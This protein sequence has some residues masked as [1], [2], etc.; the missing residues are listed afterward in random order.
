[1]VFSS[2]EL[3]M[4]VLQNGEDGIPADSKYIWV[5][6]SQNANGDPLTDDPTGAVYIGIAYNK[7]SIEESNNP[8]DYYWSKILGDKGEDAYTIILSN[9]NISFSVSYEDNLAIGDQSFTTDVRVFYGAT[10]RD[11]FVIGEIG[12]SNGIT[13]SKT[14]NSV[15]LSVTDSTK[16]TA[17]HGYF[18]IPISIDGLIFYKDMS[19]NTV[20]QGVPGS[21]GQSALNISLGNESQ[22]IPCNSE[23]VTLESFLIEIPFAAYEGFNKVACTA[24][25]GVLPSGITLGQNTGSTPD[26]DGLI[27]LNVARGSNLGGDEVLQGKVVI[28][29]IVGESEVIKNFTWTK[30][31]DGA[32]GE[33]GQFTLYSLESSAPVISKTFEDTFSPESITFSAYSMEG[34]S[35]DKTEYSGMFIIEE[36]TN[37]T[38]Y[39]TSYLSSADEQSVTF[40]PTSINVISIRCTLY[41]AGG[42]TSALDIYTVPVLTDVDNMRPIIDEITTS[43]S[44]V[45][46]KVDSVEKSIT[47]KVWQSDITTQINNYD[48]TTVKIIRDQVAETQTSLGEIRSTVSDVQTTLTNKADGSTVQTLSEKVSNIEQDANGFRQT[49]EEN[50]VTND[51]LDENSKTLRSEFNQTAGE[52][53]QSVTDLSGNI[54]TITQDVTAIK[55]RVEDAEGNITSLEETA[56]GL[57]TRVENN[58]GD[59]STLQQTVSGFNQTV[60]NLE[61]DIS[62]INQN[63]EGITQRVSDAEGDISSFQQTASNLQTQITNNAGNISQLQ[64]DS[65]G[66]K[67]TVSNTYVTKENAVTNTQTLYYLST[68]TTILSGGSWS[69]TAPE[70]IQGKYMWSKVRTTYANGTTV[71]SDPV[72]IA[73]AKGDSGNGITSTSIT[74]QTSSSGTTVPGGNWLSSIPAVASG[75]YLWTKT[76]ITYTDGTNSISY[77]VAKA[78]TD[79]KD[80]TGVTI[81]GSYDS[82]EDLKEAHPTGSIGD[83]YIVAGDLYVW[84]GSDWQNVG[85]IQGPHGNPGTDGI[86]ILSSSITYQASSSGTTPPNG[87]WLSTIPTVPDGQYLWTRTILTYTNETTSTSYSVGRNGVTGSDGTGVESIIAEYYLST[88]KETPTGGSWSTTSPVWSSGMYVW[89]RNKITYKN[90]T[91]IEYTEPICDSSWEA[92]NDIEVGGR[93]LWLNSSFNFDFNGYTLELNDGTIQIAEDKFNG[94]N[95]A[96]FE[97]VD[98]TGSLRCFVNTIESSS[99]NNYASGEQFILSAWVFI[100]T[101]LDADNNEIMVRGSAGDTPSISIPMT[102]ETGKWIKLTSPVYTASLAGT[103]ESCYILLGKNGKLKVSQIKLEKGNKPTDWTP[104]P[105]DMATS[106]EVQNAQDSADEANDGLDDANNRLD[107]A[108]STIEQLSDSISMLITDENGESMMTQTSDGWRFDISNITNSLEDARETVDNL[109]GTVGNLDS[110]VKNLDQLIDDITKKTAYIIMTTDDEG[111]PCIELGKEDNPFKVRITN[112]S[113][114]FMEGTSR[115]AYVSNK[116]LFIETAIIK[117]ELQIGEGIGFIWKRRSNGNMGLRWIGGVD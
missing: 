100:E 59:I 48:N 95:I 109:S 34:N 3:D 81:L 64:Q 98:Y 93:N 101:A 86:G 58:E 39:D 49:V 28:T 15:T 55:Q 30:T 97:R 7:D 29:F 65:E 9:E 43:I 105:E 108:E 115:I 21:V 38:T 111:N 10:E 50:Y 56:S 104:A 117:N 22:N 72:C 113:V 45:E 24:S 17:K 99:I 12:S 18:R 27:I 74:Y 4:L 80:G 88:S 78:G 103:F 53:S 47:D 77:S 73:G 6:Y 2:N 44:G 62:S 94:N 90:P 79:G 26:T 19:W 83:S 40:T 23:G 82:E 16:I 67:T 57:A 116:T 63:V 91:S 102:T 89:T 107:T 112:T 8:N 114:D 31:K 14:V 37:G 46:S 61:G 70:W 13:V 66:F 110:T 76:E 20:P 68:S 54:T 11:D 33:A 69:E 1:M 106:E 85:N 42:I 96:V 75:Q 84:N 32:T 52:I 87:T 92:V 35:G 5:K 41:K 60:A 36:S 71:E 51:D 25:V